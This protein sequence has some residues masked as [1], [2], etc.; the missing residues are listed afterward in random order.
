M[1]GILKLF[2]TLG[3]DRQNS[4]DFPFFGQNVKS[5]IKLRQFLVSGV[6][7]QAEN[8]TQDMERTDTGVK[9]WSP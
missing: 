9:L 6:L 3:R 1:T 7:I 2:W 8:N 5:N 4:S